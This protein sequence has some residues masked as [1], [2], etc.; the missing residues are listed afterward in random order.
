MRIILVILLVI[1]FVTEHNN[2]KGYPR[3]C[4]KNPSRTLVVVVVAAVVVVVVVVVVVIVVMVVRKY[5]RASRGPPFC[6]NTPAP[7]RPL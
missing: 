3:C 2:L 5:W 4:I 7:S 6:F 1:R